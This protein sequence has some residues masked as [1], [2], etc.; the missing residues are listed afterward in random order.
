MIRTTGHAESCTLCN[1][2]PPQRK[3]PYPHCVCAHRP[4]ELGDEGQ[5]QNLS[6]LAWPWRGA[7][8]LC[9]FHVTMKWIMRNTSRANKDRESYQN[10]MTVLSRAP[11]S[12]QGLG[13]F[14]LKRKISG[15][16]PVSGS[17]KAMLGISWRITTCT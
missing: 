2:A 8:N 15:G 6:D 3:R 11:S 7:P 9:T 5:K 12:Q 10:N 4:V 17:K 13:T 14:P 1:L 16:S